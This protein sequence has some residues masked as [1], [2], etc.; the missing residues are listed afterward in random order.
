M[1]AVACLAICTLRSLDKKR[2]TL[3]SNSQLRA[4]TCDS[5]LKPWPTHLNLFIM[6]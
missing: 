5:S 2:M 4:L 3:M 6:T 1:G